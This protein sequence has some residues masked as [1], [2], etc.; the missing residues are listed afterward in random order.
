MD[1]EQHKRRVRDSM[2]ELKRLNEAEER[3]K[4]RKIEAEA[5]DILERTFSHAYRDGIGG[6]ARTNR[7]SFAIRAPYLPS[8]INGKR[9]E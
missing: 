2:A 8:I 9:E 1:Q 7:G 4:D 5:D 6:H 3:D